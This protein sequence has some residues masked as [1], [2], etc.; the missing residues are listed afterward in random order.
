[1]NTPAESAPARGDG[2]A[3]GSAERL[4]RE[5]GISPE[6]ARKLADAGHLDAREVRSLPVAALLETGLTTEEA[7]RVRTAP[8]AAPVDQSAAEREEAIAERLMSSVRTRDGPQRR[9]TSPAAARTSAEVLKRWMDGDEAAMQAWMHSLPSAPATPSPEAPALVPPGPEPVTPSVGPPPAAPSPAPSGGIRRPGE[10]GAELA[11]REKAVVAWLTELLDRVKSDRFDPNSLLQELTGLQRELSEERARRARLEEESEQ[12]KRGS[13]AVIKYVRSREAAS[14]EQAVRERD[15]E[16]SALKLKLLQAAEPGKGPTAPAAPDPELEARLRRDF[17]ERE[18]ALV[19]REEELRKRLTQAESDLRESRGEAANVRARED[20]LKEKE[21]ALPEAL[22][23]KLQTLDSRERDIAAREGELQAKFEEIKSAADQLERQREPMRFKEKQLGEWEVQLRTLKQTLEVEARTIERSRLEVHEAGPSLADRQRLEE[24][25]I[26]LGRR[27]E[28]LLSR[29][30]HLRQQV[31]DLQSRVA[32]QDAEAM[33]A[34][35][36]ADVKEARQTTGV[37]RLDDLL[38]GGLPSGAQVLVSGPAHTGKELLA[39]LFIAEGLKRG[40]PAIWV[41]TDKTFGQVR[42][43]MV[44][45]LPS[46]RELEGRGLVRYVDLY[47]RSL[48]VT[49]SE[50]GVRFFQSTDRGVLDQLTQAVNTFSQELKERAPT[51]RLVFESVSTVTAYLDS[52]A[53]FRF[54]Q[55]FTGRRKLDGAVAYYLLEAG[56]HSE[57]DLETLEH[58]VDG[59]VNLKVEQLKTFLSVRGVTEV[60]SRAWVGYTFTRRAFSLGSF[61][62]DHIR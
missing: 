37:R 40:I 5:L 42:E 29:E 50:P 53:T 46:Y 45:L 4:A 14:R 11:D 39:R 21:R 56:M 38:F 35:A 33:H 3:G 24:L 36:I 55:P 59:S 34:E 31:Q 44:S 15:A 19:D 25:K 26:D 28:A 54:L 47:S 27:E 1:M 51:Y 32:S 7:E 9:R 61:S 23:T 60:Q 2:P 8:E 20:L 6:I 17:A 18:A 10:G 22:A 41:V 58:M 52:A 30:Q 12:V 62:L 16:I 57:S 48:G 43:E 13:I 49:Q